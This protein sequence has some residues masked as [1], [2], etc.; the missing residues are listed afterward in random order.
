MIYKN[1]L[2]FYITF[3]W[4]LSKKSLLEIW[5]LIDRILGNEI[6][7][8]GKCTLTFSF[9]LIYFFLR[10]MKVVTQVMFRYTNMNLNKKLFIWPSF[11]SL[12]LANVYWKN[13]PIINFLIY[14]ITDVNERRLHKLKKNTG[15][16]INIGTN[17]KGR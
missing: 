16:P 9:F 17:F 14:F 3:N 12:S 8:L 7:W 11:S 15:C 5:L 2:L 6:I 10:E 13:E 1:S 4:S